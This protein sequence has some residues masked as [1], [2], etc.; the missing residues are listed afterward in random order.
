[1]GKANSFRDREKRGM[2]GE[3]KEFKNNGFKYINGK[4]NASAHYLCW[5]EVVACTKIVPFF[6]PIFFVF[7]FITILLFTT[8][9]TTSKLN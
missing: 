5:N 7:N 4:T 6:I 1:M 2:E 8:G 9:S 3:E